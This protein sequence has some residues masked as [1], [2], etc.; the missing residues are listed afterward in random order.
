MPRPMASQKYWADR[1]Q[2]CAKKCKV[3]LAHMTDKQPTKQR[4]G[5]PRGRSKGYTNR[6]TR[7]EG[8]PPETHLHGIVGKVVDLYGTIDGRLKA[9]NWNWVTLAKQI[10]CSRQYVVDLVFSKDTM[11]HDFFCRL[12]QVLDLDPQ[13]LI[14]PIDE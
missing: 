7:P 6:A 12:C 2:I 10:P 14:Q 4:R 3:I 1:L 9:L 5:I 8:V 11:P 13:S